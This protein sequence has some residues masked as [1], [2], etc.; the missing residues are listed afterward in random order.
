MTV[1]LGLIGVGRWGR[2]YVN[3]IAAIPDVAELK[4][5]ASAS[6]V[7]DCLLLPTNC[8]LHTDWREI[9][10]ANDID[11]VIVATPTSLH[12][13]IA[14]ACIENGLGVLVEKPLTTELSS[15][16]RLLHLTEALGGLVLVNHIHLFHPAYEQLKKLVKASRSLRTIESIGGNWG[17]FRPDTPPLW[18]WGPHDLALCLDLV[19][20]MP[21]AVTAASIER[22]ATVEGYGEIVE[23]NLQFQNKI[24]ARVTVGN[25]M[26]TKCRRFTAHCTDQT[27]VYDDTR[28]R[29]LQ[30]IAT[31]QGQ[32]AALADKQNIDVSN[33]SPLENAVRHLASAIASDSR[34]LS[35][36]ELAVNVTAILSNCDKMLEKYG[37][38]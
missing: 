10:K 16:Q 6:P 30:R 14:T 29:K 9:V 38:L 15:A 4:R 21:E 18:D 20:E 5:V 7:S 3:T 28:S 25:I 32:N 1:R 2:N 26:Q 12:T 31:T 35:N 8:T 17:P 19:G 33:T 22:S 27:F 11:G 36:L 23:L 34:D 37:R 24:T 13:T